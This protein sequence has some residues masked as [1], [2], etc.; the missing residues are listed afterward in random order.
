M[1]G[2]LQA[3]G[4][5]QAGAGVLGAISSIADGAAK[6]AAAD[7]VAAVTQA[8][9]RMR[10]A[11]IRR[12][13]VQELGSARAA[14]AA[15]GVKLSS[16]SVLA[17]EGDIARYS[18]QDAMSVLLSGQTEANALRTRGR[19]AFAAGFMGASDSLVHGADAWAR[20]RRGKDNVGYAP[21][22]AQ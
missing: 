18:E 1:G 13:G 21:P 19:Q 11:S 8:G 5:L 22:G 12:A 14:A 20:T 17:A 3:G 16:G 9:A 15:S 4:A 10:A 2:G 7:G 6:R